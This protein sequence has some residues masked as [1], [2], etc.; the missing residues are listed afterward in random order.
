MI[1]DPCDM[2]ICDECVGI[3]DEILEE[4]IDTDGEK[5]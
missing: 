4:E 3:C 2:F 5:E 1:A